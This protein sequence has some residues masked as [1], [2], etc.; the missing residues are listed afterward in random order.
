MAQLW[1]RHGG[2]PVN[3]GERRVIEFLCEN[4]PDEYYII[5]DIQVPSQNQVDEIDAI[6]VSPLAV[7]VL[8]IKDYAGRVVFRQQEHLVDGEKRRNPLYQNGQ[9]SRRLKGKLVTS[10]S[11]FE[12]VWVAPQIILARKPQQLLIEPEIEDQVVLLDEAPQRL[13]DAAVMLPDRHRNDPVDVDGVLQALGVAGKQRRRTETYGAYRTT[14]LLEQDLTGRLYEATHVLNDKAVLLRVHEISGFLKN[15][16]K[17]AAHDRALKSFNALTLLTD[18]TGGAPQVVGPTEAFPTDTHDIV[19]ITPFD[20][21]TPLSDLIDAKVGL[22]EEFRLAIIRDIAEAVKAAHATRVGVAHRGLNPTVVYVDTH[23]TDPLELVARVGGW[24]RA[25]LGTDYSGT[26]YSSLH[27][28]SAEFVAPEVVNGG[29][30][31]WQPADLWSLGALVSAVWIRLSPDP[32][33]ETLPEAL[34]QLAQVLANEDPEERAEVSAFEVADTAAA[35]L[36]DAAAPQDVQ[37]EE[38]GDLT[39]GSLIGDRYRVFGVLG[40]GA[41]SRV[42]GVDDQLAGLRFALKIF[43]E[44]ISPELVQSEFGALLEANHPNIVRVNDIFQDRL[45]TCLKMELLRGQNLRAYLDEHGPLEPDQALRWFDKLLAAFEILHGTGDRT[46]I[47]HRDIKPEN[48]IVAGGDRGLVAVDFG[49]AS[50]PDD[51]GGGGTRRYRPYGTSAMASGPG[52]DLFA[53]AVTL[54]EA[55]TGTHPFGDL[56]V[57]KGPPQI[58]SSLPEAVQQALMRALDPDPDQRFRSAGEFRRAITQGAVTPTPDPSETLPPDQQDAADQAEPEDTPEVGTNGDGGET[59]PLGDKVTVELMPG[60]D[61]RT[62]AETPSGEVD[63]EVTVA[64]ARVH[65]EPGIRLDI[66]WC[67]ADH[68]ETWIKA[69]DAHRS[70]PS[71]HRL[72]HGLRPG[73]RPV[74]GDVSAAFM[75]LRQARIIDDPN[76]PRLRKVPQAEL[77]DGAGVDVAEVLTGLGARTV[78]TRQIA[79][80]DTGPRRTDFCVVFEPDSLAVPVAAYALTRVAPLVDHQDSDGLSPADSGSETPL[81]VPWPDLDARMSLGKGG[82]GDSWKDHHGYWACHEQNP[83]REPRIPFATIRSALFGPSGA[84]ALFTG[85]GRVAVR[86]QRWGPVVAVVV[87]IENTALITDGVEIGAVSWRTVPEGE[88]DQVLAL[89]RSSQERRPLSEPALS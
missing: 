28:G 85:R 27:V 2:E 70:P 29:V 18:Q 62:E 43:R 59:I 74:P 41:T 13:T 4:L 57:C 61:R 37:G 21:G 67:Q 50:R 3:D 10:S 25:N 1:N 75:E 51:A 16:A 17:Q 31:A 78:A 39:E 55:L 82:M 40:E 34:E 89:L 56:E 44:A 5:P 20:T 68:G 87:R 69:V 54:H 11:A 53:L 71:I 65:A 35:L 45:G 8:E 46:P 76:W 66:E 15:G 81:V 9:R 48:L 79:W 26:V 60:R 33:A 73:I 58:D 7:V 47:V 23:R 22:A 36:R 72:L 6:L 30:E 19:T 64:R 49:L 14:K 52:L 84:L 42:F 86:T 12:S 32:N 80:G 77:D 88:P 24:D 83:W 38:L 63:V